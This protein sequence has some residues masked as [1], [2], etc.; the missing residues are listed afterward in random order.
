MNWKKIIIVSCFLFLMLSIFLFWTGFHN[1][2]ICVNEMNIEDNFNINLSELKISE[3]VWSLTDC[4]LDGLI[5]LVIGFHMGIVSVFLLG[6]SV[7]KKE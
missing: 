2:D 1:V 4:Y 3:N 5:K 7:C 6:M